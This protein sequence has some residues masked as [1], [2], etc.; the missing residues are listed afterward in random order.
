MSLI[1]VGAFSIRKPFLTPNPDI[2][3]LGHLK[4]WTQELWFHTRDD[5]VHSDSLRCSHHLTSKTLNYEQMVNSLRV[6]ILLCECMQPVIFF[7]EHLPGSKSLGD[8]CEEKG[9]KSETLQSECPV[10]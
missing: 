1:S 4:H 5:A 7:M 8:S 6:G 9:Q 2:L 10:P 3:S